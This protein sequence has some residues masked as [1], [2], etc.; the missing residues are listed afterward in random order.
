M[1]NEKPQIVFVYPHHS[2]GYEKDIFAPYFGAAYLRA[3]L[4]ENGIPSGQYVQIKPARISETIG[5]LSDSGARK[6]GFTCYDTNYYYVKIIAEALKTADP[7]IEII[8]G[9]PTATFSDQLIMADCPAIDVCCRGESEFTLPELLNESRLGDIRGITYREN[10][11]I[12]RNENRGLCFEGDRNQLDIFPSP[13]SGGIID[14]NWPGIYPI[15][16]VR[17]CRFDCTYCNFPGISGHRLRYHSLDRVLEDFRII[18]HLSEKNGERIVM[19]F[20]DSLGGTGKRAK[21]I[22]EMMIANNIALPLRADIRVEDVDRDLFKMMR[23]AG[24]FMLNIGLESANPRILRNVNKL[25]TMNR[26]DT[27]F[28]KEKQY[29][30][31]IRLAVKW[32]HEADINITVSV[33]QGLPGETEKEARETID[34]VSDLNV[35]N[36]HHNHLKIFPGTRLFDDHERFGIRIRPSATVLP[37]E[38]I[39]SYRLETIR[40]RKN[41]DAYR[42]GKRIAYE[43]ISGFFGI[44]NVHV[45][46]DANTYA[47]FDE[48][49]SPSPEL[50]AWMG[51]HLR[52]F[53][54]IAFRTETE[55]SGE[56]RADLTKAIA[57]HRIPSLHVYFFNP[58]GENRPKKWTLTYSSQYKPFHLVKTAVGVLSHSFA[59]DSAEASEQPGYQLMLAFENDADIDIPDDELGK[60]GKQLI[61]RNAVLSDGCRWAPAPCPGTR[62]NRIIVNRNGQIAPCFASSM[63]SE[64]WGDPDEMKA[65]WRIATRNESQRRGCDTCPAEP[66]CS[67]CLCT[68]P[69]SPEAFCRIQ[70]QG[71]FPRLYRKALDLCAICWEKV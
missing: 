32:A 8:A 21:Q 62:F 38:T 5:K 59:D 14:A 19:V 60:I 51:R 61:K 40:P 53:D 15:Q 22:C 64:A 4:G 30:E 68:A 10:G 43:M 6:I 33:I 9:G 17:G 31:K 23:E 12:L 67:K 24:F 41:S 3:F 16:T 20:D 44:W 18:K 26:T 69:F 56:N 42:A 66:A 13:H 48:F 25:L 47:L 49:T 70:R 29:L 39:P 1:A 63:K 57:E 11:K 58:E 45:A 54:R 71:I 55:V 34:F 2:Q 28:H 65:K 35:G 52:F 7:G 27:D 46:E 37:Y 36:Y 50:F